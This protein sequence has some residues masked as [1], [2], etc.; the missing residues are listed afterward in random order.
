MSDAVS[1]ERIVA[2][3]GA[4]M[5]VEQVGE[6][7]ATSSQFIVVPTDIHIHGR[8]QPSACIET[9]PD[10]R[11]FGRPFNDSYQCRDIT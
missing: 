4:A 11:W 6:L 3:R 5:D 2:V 10:G 1:K 9:R 7:L 8:I